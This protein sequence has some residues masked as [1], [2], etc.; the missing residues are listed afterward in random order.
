[1]EGGEPC[2]HL[3]GGV[4][5]QEELGAPGGGKTQDISPLGV[6]SGDLHLG[7]TEGYLFLN[8]QGCLWRE[9]TTINM[10]YKEI[11]NEEQPREHLLAHI[12]LLVITF[13]IQNEM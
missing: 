11:Q 4:C 2:Q 8:S 12:R 9:E 6:V 13:T 1:M 7:T 3:R 5:L 10:L